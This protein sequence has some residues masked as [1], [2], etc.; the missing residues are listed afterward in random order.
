MRPEVGALLEEMKL[1][2]HFRGCIG[3]QGLLPASAPR[4]LLQREVL[5]SITGK[6]GVHSVVSA[7]P[8]ESFW[9]QLPIRKRSIHQ[10]PCIPSALIFLRQGLFT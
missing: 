2:L 1:V 6:L 9:P 8:W 10:C 4:A 5:G 7:S 3:L